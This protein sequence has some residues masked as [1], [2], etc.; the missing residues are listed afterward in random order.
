MPAGCKHVFGSSASGSVED[1]LR[2][3]RASGLVVQ[4]HVVRPYSSSSSS[5]SSASVP[6]GGAGWAGGS[7]GIRDFLAVVG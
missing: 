1:L 6:M 7:L 5:A 4:E 2:H 3:A